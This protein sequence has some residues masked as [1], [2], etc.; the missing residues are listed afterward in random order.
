MTYVTENRESI[1][2]LL[3]SARGGSIKMINKLHLAM[4]ELY[5]GDAKRIQHFCK[6]HSYAKLIAE[7]E[8]V[9]KECLFIIEAA[10]LTH[11]IGIHFCEEKYGNCNGKLQEKEGPAIADKMLKELGF[12]Q[13]VSDRVQYLIAH[14]H[15]YNNIDEIDYQILVEADFLVNIMEDGLSKEAALKAYESIFKT[16]CGKMICREMFDYA[17]KYRQNATVNF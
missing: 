14:H 4:I 15:T 3:Y 1:Q 7:T 9:D 12:D 10:A 2:K 11:D 6:V 17:G 5:R 16:T 8:N 13:D